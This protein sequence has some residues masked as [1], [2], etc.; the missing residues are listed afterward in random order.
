VI[1]MLAGMLA[2]PKVEGLLIP[3]QVEPQS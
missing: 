1:G 3:R 2:A